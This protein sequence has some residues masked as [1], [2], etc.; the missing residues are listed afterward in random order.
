MD[1]GGEDRKAGGYRMLRLEELVLPAV[2][3]ASGGTWTVEEP[4]DAKARIPGMRVVYTLEG[5]AR[6]GRWDTYRIGAKAREN[7]ARKT[8]TEATFW[9]EKTSGTLV[10]IHK[11]LT[12]VPSPVP[13]GAFDSGEWDLTRES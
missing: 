11:K 7:G 4:E 3:V 6:V 2:P 9:I 1:D 8:A 13:Q 10:R 5:E 12:D